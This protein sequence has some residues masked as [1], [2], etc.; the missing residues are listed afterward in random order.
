MARIIVLGAKVPF[1]SGGQ[2]VLVQTLKKELIQRGHQADIVELP[3]NTYSKAN[4]INQAAEWRSA[5]LQEILEK[6]ADLV[7]AT[8]FPT[9]YVKHKCKSVWLVHQLRNLYDLFGGRYSDISDDPRDESLRRVLMEGD[10]KTLQEA[11]YL[12]SISKNVS[13]RLQNFNGLTSEVLY[14]PLPLGTQYYSAQAQPYIL[15]VGRLC[16]IKRVDLMIKAMPHVH[17]SHT[18]KIVGTPDHPGIMDYFNNE[19]AKHDL[20][21]RIHFLGRVDNAELLRL[22][23]ECR[24]VYYAPLEEDYGYVTIE[25]MASGKPVI[26]ARDSG[27]VLEF[28]K[29]QENGLICE[30]ATSEEFAHACNR[31]I[32]N[33]E[34]AQRLGETGKRQILDLGMHESGWDTII[35]RLLSPL[36]K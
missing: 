33:P 32:E 5:T 1:A 36:G 16:D 28:I 3:F 15:S 18:L 11:C 23:A 10:T 26:T 27:G 25:A 21:S 8:K 24:A 19:I 31:L 22:Y 7:I 13:E 9:Y 35:S 4:L 30:Q 14:P 2:E 6:S 29:D 20:K 34:L 17:I 12:S